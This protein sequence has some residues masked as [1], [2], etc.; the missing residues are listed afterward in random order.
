[1]Y[2]LS[3]VILT[4]LSFLLAIVT[5]VYYYSCNQIK[6]TFENEDKFSDDLTE[7][8]NLLLNLRKR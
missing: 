3:L 4:I 2:N 5:S 1:M 6:E 8:K 7:A